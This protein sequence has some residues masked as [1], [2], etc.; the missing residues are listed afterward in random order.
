MVWEDRQ[1][2]K[3]WDSKHWLDD[4]WMQQEGEEAAIAFYRRRRLMQG[5]VHWVIRTA[6]TMAVWDA[7]GDKAKSGVDWIKGDFPGGTGPPG[8]FLD[9][10]ARVNSKS[11]LAGKILEDAVKQHRETALIRIP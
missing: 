10:G 7:I 1:E 8:K 6:A 11:K 4:M 5:Q 3:E 9:V 2:A